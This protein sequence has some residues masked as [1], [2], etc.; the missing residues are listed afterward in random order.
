MTSPH[1]LCASG[2]TTSAATYT[3]KAGQLPPSSLVDAAWQQQG[4]SANMSAHSAK[5]AGP[6]RKHTRAWQVLVG[7]AA[8]C[9]LADEGEPDLAQLPGWC[10]PVWSAA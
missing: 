8:S 4:C 3:E 2:S 9:S 10:S 1:L 7:C 6:A 5:S